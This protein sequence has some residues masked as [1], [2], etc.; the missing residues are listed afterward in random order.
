[1]T[2][3]EPSVL[4]LLA[5]DD[6]LIRM[7]LEE[8]LA[9]AGFDLA[10]TTNGRE[11]MAELEVGAARFC[12]LVT[13]IRLGRGPDGWQIAHRARE[14]VPEIPVVY[15]SGDSAFEWASRGVP[16]SVMVSKP[17][18]LEEVVSALSE[19]LA[20]DGPSTGLRGHNDQG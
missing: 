3:I 11:A 2:P 15:I 17:F 8:E 18:H 4:L 16:N 10:V 19:L 20:Q 6:V 5:E 12:A 14:V 9:E 1:V 7:N 13:D